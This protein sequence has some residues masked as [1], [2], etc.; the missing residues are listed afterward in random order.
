MDKKYTVPKTKEGVL[1]KIISLAIKDE[2][3]CLVWQNSKSPRGYGKIKFNN[4]HWRAHRLMYFIKFGALDDTTYVC[5]S[6]DNPS[7]INPDHLFAG[8]ARDNA[9]DMKSKGRQNNQWTIGPR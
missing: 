5:H 1:K 8:T 4:K 3:G 9:E 7:C 6:C 2:N